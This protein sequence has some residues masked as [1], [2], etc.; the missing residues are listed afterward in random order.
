[1]TQRDSDFDTELDPAL[2]E[3]GEDDPWDEPL[4][5]PGWVSAAIG[6]VLVLIAALAVWHGAGVGGVGR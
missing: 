3:S 1:L 5:F 4:E 6:V 2:V